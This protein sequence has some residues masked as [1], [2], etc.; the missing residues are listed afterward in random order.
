MLP[1]LLALLSAFAAA[2][3]ASTAVF[4]C[5]AAECRTRLRAAV[6]LFLL[7]MMVGM[8]LGALVYVLWPSRQSA[9]DGLWL[10]SVVMSASAVVVFVAFVREAQRLASESAPRG[11]VPPG[12]SF[13]PMVILLVFLGEALMG[14]TFGAAASWLPRFPSA[15]VGGGLEE[16]GK[17]VVAPW[18]T[19]PMVGEMALSWAWLRGRLDPALASLL[20]FQPVIMLCSPPTLPGLGWV[21]GSTIGSAVAMGGAVAFLVVAVHRG[22]QLNRRFLAYGGGLL[23]S[24]VLMALGLALWALSGSLAVLAFAITAQ[25][26]VYLAAVLWPSPTLRASSPPFPSTGVAGAAELPGGP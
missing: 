10:A 18:F 5:W 9:V 7:L 3:A 1:W 8:L 2:M 21:V 11:P 24:F 6:V 16:F 14:W 17:V 22:R 4:I 19:F 23:L 13:V 12:R 20:A 26:V 15:G 25:M